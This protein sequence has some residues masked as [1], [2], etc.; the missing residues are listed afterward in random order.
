MVWKTTMDEKKKYLRLQIKEFTTK[1]KRKD[2]GE[3]L[4]NTLRQRVER[5][6]AQVNQ[7]DS[8]KIHPVKV[9]NGI[10]INGKLINEYL[11]K[12][13]GKHVMYEITSDHLILHFQDRL[14][15]SK[16]TLNDLSGYFTGW[17]I[18]EWDSGDLIDCKR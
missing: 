1:L 14:S 12:S 13:K 5:L 10:I 17:D 3:A 18:P 4:R 15:N 6:Q 11:K 16:I 8:R 7:Y 9:N 2:T